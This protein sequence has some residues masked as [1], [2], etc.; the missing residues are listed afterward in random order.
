MPGTESERWRV[1]ADRTANRLRLIQA[2]LADEP[3]AARQEHLAE[4][5]RSALG[6]VDPAERNAFLE[7]VEERFPG[8][9]GGRVVTRGDGAGGA[10][11][12][13]PTDIAELNDP[14][15]L[16]RQ[17][18]KNAD[19][20]TAEQK[21][22]VG[23]QLAAAGIAPEGVGSIP[24]DAVER[25]K[26]A[27][28]IQAGGDAD[29]GRMLDVLAAVAPQLLS[30]DA[31]VWPTWR[32]MAPGSAIKRRQEL[33]AVLRSYAGGGSEVGREQVLEE[34]G[35]F[36]Q[37]TAALL[38]SIAKAGELAYGQTA[39]MDP[40]AIESVARNEKKWNESLELACWRKFSELAGS[41]DQTAVESEMIAAM[42]GYAEKLMRP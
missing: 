4:E 2:D 25:A 41:I 7:A 18:V 16:V 3:A 13:A 35:R 9:E 17:L 8:W 21:K 27:L 19:K 6:E 36:R 28:K 10:G 33:A 40:H 42:A 5:V 31:L 24:V 32:K 29:V 37:L 38:A 20:L 30:L 12:A 14:A 23:A 34:L 15:F 39:K 11:V 26:A 1:L 22:A